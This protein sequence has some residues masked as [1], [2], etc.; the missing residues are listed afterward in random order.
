M[1]LAGAAESNEALPPAAPLLWSPSTETGIPRL[2]PGSSHFA[3]EA[4][5]QGPPK[6]TLFSNR[7]KIPSP[8]D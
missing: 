2:G 3:H 4:L 8:S 5:Q 1:S 7:R 6:L